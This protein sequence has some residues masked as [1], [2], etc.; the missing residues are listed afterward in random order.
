MFLYITIKLLYL[1][2]EWV[3]AKLYRRM[4][5]RLAENVKLT[6]KFNLIS[7]SNTK[8]ALTFISLIENAFK[9]GDQR[10]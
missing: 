10:R 8:I 5:I 6:T 7:N 3:H 4:R 1:V 2:A 9:H